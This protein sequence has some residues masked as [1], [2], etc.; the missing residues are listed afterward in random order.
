MLYICDECGV[1]FSKASN[2]GRHKKNFHNLNFLC[3]LCGFQTNDKQTSITHKKQ[4]AQEYFQCKHCNEKIKNK[5]N[6]VRHL[7]EQ[8]GRDSFSCVQCN[9]ETSREHRLNEHMKLHISKPSSQRLQNTKTIHQ[10][11]HRDGATSQDEATIQG[12]V[13]KSAFRGKMQERSW[14]RVSQK[15][16][17]Q[18]FHAYFSE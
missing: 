17:C 18:D 12:E 8:H 9:Y 10:P 3:Y 7:K 5:F 16:W 6:F 15:K 11:I 13:V 14:Y 2:L 1:Q 4:H